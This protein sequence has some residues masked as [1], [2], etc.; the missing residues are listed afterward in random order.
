[1]PEKK[2]YNVTIAGMPLKVRSS[3]DEEKV[4][5][6]IDLVDLRVSSTLSRTKSKSFQKAVLLAMLNLA[7]EYLVMKD[8]VRKD[9]DKIENKAIDM[10]SE[11]ESTRIDRLGIGH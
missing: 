2:T 3:T 8:R 7:D 11:L 9:L 10:V 6:L 5:E 1:V 4:K